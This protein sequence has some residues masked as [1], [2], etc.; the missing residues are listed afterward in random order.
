MSDRGVVVT[1][2]FWVHDER[3]HLESSELDPVGLRRWLLYWDRLDWP[4]NNALRLDSTSEE[5]SLLR[6][7][8]ILT[9][10][11]VITG[12]ASVGGALVLSQVAA[13][14]KRVGE[15]P[16]AWSLAQG[17]PDLQLPNAPAPEAKFVEFELVRALPVPAA[18]VPIQDILEF[19][20]RRGEELLRFRH[21]MDRAYQEVLQSEDTERALRTAK[22]ELEGALDALGRVFSESFASRVISSLKVELDVSGPIRSGLGGEAVGFLAGVPLGLGILFGTAMSAVNVSVAR[23]PRLANLPEKVRDYAYLGYV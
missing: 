16:R 13:F 22:E 6:D 3:V 9:R 10:T 1:S 23:A 21:T 20:E 5:I 11:E 14:L 8:E 12:S 7:E 17:H 4:V 18:D 15:E 19:K 2:P